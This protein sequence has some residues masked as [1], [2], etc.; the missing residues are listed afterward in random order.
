MI[1]ARMFCTAGAMALG[2]AVCGAQVRG[3]PSDAFILEQRVGDRWLHAA[4]QHLFTPFRDARNFLVLT[5][6]AGD[7]AGMMT[8]AV[9][10]ETGSRVNNMSAIR[11]QVAADGHIINVA[12]AARP[13]QSSLRMTARDSMRQVDAVNYETLPERA[14]LMPEARVWEIVP[15]VR[16]PVLRVGARWTDTVA[17]SASAPRHTQSLAGIRSS[18]VAGDTTVAGRTLWIIADSMDASITEQFVEDELSLLT[19]VT[20][21]RRARGVIR[22]RHLYDPSLRLFRFRFDTTALTGTVT[23][24]YPDGRSFSTPARFDRRREYT[25]HSIQEYGARVTQ[26]AQHPEVTTDRAPNSAFSEVV[27]RLRAGEARATDSVFALWNSSRDP[28]ERLRILSRSSGTGWGR[29][30]GAA[31]SARINEALR[32]SGDSSLVRASLLAAPRQWTVPVVRDVL[33]P[34][35]AEPA[36]ALARGESVDGFYRIVVRVMVESPAA[37]ERDTAR[38]PLSPS[39]YE[40][41]AQQGRSAVEPRLRD[42]GLLSLFVRDP[43]RWADS[44]RGRARLGSQIVQEAALMADGV[45]SSPPSPPLGVPDSGATWREWYSWMGPLPP[46]MINRAPYTPLFINRPVVRDRMMPFGPAHVRAVRMFELRTGRPVVAELRRQLTGADSDSAR[47]VF[48]TILQGLGEMPV[49]G[50]EIAAKFRMGDASDIQLA[51]AALMELLRTANATGRG[52]GPAGAAIAPVDSATHVAVTT[53]L[54]QAIL[55]LGAPL[56]NLEQKRNLG[57]GQRVFLAP[58]N[59]GSVFTTDSLPAA[60]VARFRDSA[61]FIRAADYNPLD[62]NEGR[63]VIRI[64]RVSRIGPIIEV[65][66]SWSTLYTVN[67]VR[68]GGGGAGVLHLLDIDGEWVVVSQTG[69]VS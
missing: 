4:Q 15:V 62:P 50:A 57:A 11:M 45:G 51:R 46:G 44:V 32:Q 9:T 33:I 52:R 40:F 66:F 35:H 47:L 23:L 68:R 41:L 39:V 69:G 56:Q 10:L 24:R 28:L 5:P 27:Q 58:M 65:R 20:I 38:W 30:G 14:F 48:G 61:S 63:Q 2:T 67:G 1:L 36:G 34:S 53:R 25:L 49:D 13:L 12:A 29:A 19:Q 22:G 21:E 26:L 59:D 7:T 31:L 64:G 18:V 54:I 43:N 17:L 3:G 8:L 42:L 6:Q 55:R 16:T 60:T 37:L